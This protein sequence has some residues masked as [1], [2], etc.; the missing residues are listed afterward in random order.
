M[1]KVLGKFRSTDI[2]AIERYGDGSRL[3]LSNGEIILTDQNYDRLV[4]ELHARERGENHATCSCAK[5]IRRVGA[6]EDLQ[7]VYG[8]FCLAW[9]YVEPARA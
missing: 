7:I 9:R 4:Q 8:N 3:H 6:D 2:E 5:V 1:A